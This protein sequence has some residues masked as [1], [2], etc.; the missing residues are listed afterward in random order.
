MRG[1]SDAILSGRPDGKNWSAK[2]IV[3]GS[4]AHDDSHLDHLERALEGRP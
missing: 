4:A 2:E 1:Y 3:S